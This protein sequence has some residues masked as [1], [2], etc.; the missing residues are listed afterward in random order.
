M[1]G[2]IKSIIVLNALITVSYGFT[3]R[4]HAPS[5]PKISSSLM[6]SNLKDIFNSLTFPGVPSLKSEDMDRFC[7]ARELVRSLVEEEKCFSEES[8]AMA[9]GDVCAINCIYEDCFEPQP[10][11]GKQVCI[12][13]QKSTDEGYPI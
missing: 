4:R 1:N 11:V 9:F 7:K 5:S 13:A 8:G 6:V 2:I 3:T 12:D 10:F